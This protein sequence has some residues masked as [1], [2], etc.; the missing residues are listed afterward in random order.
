MDDAYPRVFLILG[1]DDERHNDFQV[2]Q[3]METSLWEYVHCQKV[4]FG[5]FNVYGYSYIPPTP[6]LLK[7]WERY[8]VSRYVDPG[9]IPPVAGWRTDK[10]SNNEITHGTIKKD[11]DD[12]VG[13]A[14]LSQ[15]IFVFHAP[16]YQT[17]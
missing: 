3:G 14:D 4:K 13:N 10:P 9:C 8:D 2:I 17:N 1:N 7:D 16:P 15:A 11:I 6:F 12:L 5:R